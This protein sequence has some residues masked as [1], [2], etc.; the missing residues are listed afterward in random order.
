M[1]FIEQKEFL[2]ERLKFVPFQHAA[3]PDQP[4][5]QQRPRALAD[6]MANMVKVDRLPPRMAQAKVERGEKVGRAVYQ[7]AVEIEN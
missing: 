4:F 1:I 7:C 5:F 2:G 6:H 3:R